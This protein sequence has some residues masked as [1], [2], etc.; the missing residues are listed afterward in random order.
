MQVE[1]RIPKLAALTAL[2]Q[3]TLKL[4]GIDVA[5]PASLIQE[6]RELALVRAGLT[7]EAIQNAIVARAD[8]RNAKDF[9]RADAIRQ[10]FSKKGVNFQDLPTGTVWRPTLQ[11]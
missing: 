2:L 6:L 4:I 9:E 1:D 3:D 8:A 7:E 10:D 5:N 11:E